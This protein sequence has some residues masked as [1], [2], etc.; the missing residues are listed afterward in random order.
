MDTFNFKYLFNK[1][2]TILMFS[3]T[4]IKYKRKVKNIPNVFIQLNNSISA[5]YKYPLF[6]INKGAG[7][8]S[9]LNFYKQRI[10]MEYLFPFQSKYEI[11]D[12]SLINIAFNVTNSMDNLLRIYEKEKT[13]M[14]Y[15]KE[16]YFLQIIIILNFLFIFIKI[17]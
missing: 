17:T 14:I 3:Y 12:Y 11:I 13:Q 2:F 15:K 9:F 7:N 16:F 10:V 4:F 5:N 6:C 1:D 8:F